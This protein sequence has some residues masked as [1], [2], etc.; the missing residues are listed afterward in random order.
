LKAKIKRK[1][2]LTNRIDLEQ[3]WFS[4]QSHDD[5]KINV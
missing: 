1:K 5:K 2:S 3:V 4:L